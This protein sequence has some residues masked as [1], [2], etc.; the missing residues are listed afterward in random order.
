MNSNQD[1]TTGSIGGKM[2]RFMLPILGALLLQSFYGAIDMLIVGQ[3]GSVTGISAVSTGSMI[4]TSITMVVSSFA[5]G[6]TVLMGQNLGRGTPE[7]IGPLVGAGIAL[8]ALVAAA[9]TVGLVGFG[10]QFAAL[11]QAPP[12][13]LEQTVQYMRICGIGAV[14]IVFY[15]FISSIFR[16]MGNSRLPLIFV[17]IASCVNIVGDIVLVAVLKL[18][19]LG[20]ALATIFAQAC[21]VLISL[22]IIRRQKL[23]FSMKLRDVR[24]G[25]DIR[26]ILKIGVPLALQ[27][28]L[29]TVG[30]WALLA[31]INGMGLAESSGYGVASKIFSIMLLVP[32]SILQSMASFIS[33]NVGAG[34]EDRATRAM[35]FGVCFGII[36]GLVFLTAMILFAEQM[37][38][39][40]TPDKDVIAQSASY[41]RAVSPDIGLGSVLFSFLGYFNGHGKSMYVMINSIAQ[42]FAL[43]IPIAYLMSSR[44]GATL[45]HMGMVNPATTI[46]GILVCIVLYFR[47]RRELGL[48]RRIS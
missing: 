39:I 3:F 30:M 2:L 22:V 34:R 11:M 29:T 14:F 47:L 42:T 44:A 27:E 45:F 6:V 36:T 28:M 32:L 25:G 8:F 7:K 43:R 46:G 15:N 1:F 10:R 20:A 38:M 26:D 31:F 48:N 33:Q 21:S 19:V 35:R 41:I 17:L 13:A 16:G 5:M 4:T 12:E 9:I 24:F 40:F 18:D 23:P 37:S